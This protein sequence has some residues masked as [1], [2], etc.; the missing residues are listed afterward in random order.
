[1]TTLH[2]R[3]RERLA[4]EVGR[5]DKQAPLTVA[6]L[7]PSPYAA[8]MSSLGYQRI[9]R[10]LN[11]TSG[12]A[13][14]RVVLDDEAENDL[15]AQTRPVS[16]ESLRPLESSQNGTSSDTTSSSE[17]ESSDA[18]ITRLT[19]ELRSTS[20]NSS[21]RL[22]RINPLVSK[23]LSDVF[24]SVSLRPDKNAKYLTEAGCGKSGLL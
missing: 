2:D 23:R 24:T 22:T 6:L 10:A 3:I 19:S 7:Y 12:I 5:L 11:E 13:C 17:L 21:R 1:M 18:S 14:E 16:Y 20:T 15:A 8:A 4:D 9:Y